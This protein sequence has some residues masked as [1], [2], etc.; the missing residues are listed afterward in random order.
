VA[1]CPCAGAISEADYSAL[2]DQVVAGLTTDP[3]LLL[4]PLA[5]R[6][7]LLGEAHRFEEAAS[8]RD[9]ADGLARALARQRRLDGLCAAGRL[10]VELPDA[11]GVVIDGGRLADAWSAGEPDAFA[12]LCPAYDATDPR[13]SAVKREDADEVATIAA[14]LDRE[15]TRVRLLSCGGEL[16]SSLPRLPRFVPTETR[17]PSGRA[18]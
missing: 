10:I 13:E 9:R 4:A 2:V 17:P 6:M 18:H 1:T 7:R 11:G 5:A 15:A 14:W 3:D 8:V 16:T 12:R